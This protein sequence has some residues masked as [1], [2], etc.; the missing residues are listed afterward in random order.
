MYSTCDVPLRKGNWPAN[1]NRGVSSIEKTRIHG[2]VSRRERAHRKRMPAFARSGTSQS[3][4]PFRGIQH[5]LHGV[6]DC[7]QKL[8]GEAL[9]IR[10]P[11]LC[12]VQVRS[13]KDFFTLALVASPTGAAKCGTSPA[14]N[15]ATC[16]QT[17]VLACCRGLVR[18]PRLPCDRLFSSGPLFSL[19]SA[20]GAL[21][22]ALLDERLRPRRYGTPSIT[23]PQSVPH[24]GRQL[25]VKRSVLQW[26]LDG[27]EP[28]H[29]TNQKN[30]RHAQL[31][32]RRSPPWAAACPQVGPAP[33]DLLRVG[34]YVRGG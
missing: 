12:P 3:R 7:L 23:S 9:T 28:E 27:L 24:C 21:G 33:P 29:S 32:R 26:C 4:L 8:W 18:C 13:F 15:G 16:T 5:G 6:R 22:V 31:R 20:F 1:Q 14:V 30:P 19:L 25:S 2:P 11:S 34:D 17:D 10:Q